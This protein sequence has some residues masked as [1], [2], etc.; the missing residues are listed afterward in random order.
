MEAW[1]FNGGPLAERPTGSLDGRR[2]KICARHPSNLVTT[3]NPDLRHVSGAVQFGYDRGLAW[4][5]RLR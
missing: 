5:R 4:F 1:Q 3:E 2:S